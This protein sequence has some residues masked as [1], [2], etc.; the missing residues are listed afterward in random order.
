M[1]NQLGLRPL[2]ILVCLAI[3]VLLAGCQTLKTMVTRDTDKPQKEE[4]E[5]PAQL[6]T[7]NEEGRLKVLWRRNI[8]RG[9]GTKYIDLTPAVTSDTV[10]AADA[11][12][13][14]VSMRRENGR[15][16]WLTRI[17]KPMGKGFM[18]VMD[19]SDTSFVTGGIGVADGSLYV[20][21]ARGEVVAL[22][23][24]DG[25]ERWRVVLTSEVL[26]T[27][28]TSPDAVFVQTSDGNLFALNREDGTQ[29]WVFHS[30]IPLATL[31]GTSTPVFDSGIVYGGFANGNIVAIDAAS[32]ELLW[33]QSV[34]LPEGTSELDRMVDVDGK[35]L[36]ERAAIVAS[37]HQGSTLAVRRS[38]G[39]PLW[40]AEV[41]STKAL[42]SGY[43]LV[44][45]VTEESEVVG[46]EQRDGTI[47]W[48][49][50]GLLRRDL[51]DPLAY[52]NYIYVGDGFGFV[53][54]IAQSDGRLVARRRVD[55]TG[56][57][58]TLHQV[59]GTVYVQSKSGRLIALDFER[60]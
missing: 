36:V 32:G 5:K 55:G 2:A 25:S 8:G 42:Q 31:R 38:D 51:T 40:T 45:L 57:Q 48:R 53:H 9:I 27:P 29:L 49:Q 30:Q 37:A 33:E 23:A 11:Y 12:G 4:S 26:S 17:G 50:D 1:N 58:P 59:D 24:A 14:L 35:P 47:A 52:S 54:V 28:T 22:S 18:N 39:Q 16:N 60:S 56:I 3:A 19:R 15:V 46:L 7:F 44:F 21:T 41:S 20:G 6:A 43:G 10:F 13:M 34:S